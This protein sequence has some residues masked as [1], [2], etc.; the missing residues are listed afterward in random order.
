MTFRPQHMPRESTHL[1]IGT[2]YHP[3]GADNGEMSKYLIPCL[4]V[5]R[6]N[7]PYNVIMLCE[8]F[9]TLKDSR[10]RCSHNLKQ[11]VQ[12]HTQDSSTV[13]LTYTNIQDLYDSPTVQPAIGLSD[14]M[15]VI[16]RPK[17]H[18]HYSRP[19]IQRV[20]RR[21]INYN[22]KISFDNALVTTKWEGLYR[23]P[24]CQDQYEFL[25]TTMSG[26]INQFSSLQTETMLQ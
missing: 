15:V 13:D 19:T 5:V 8:I 17:L 3:P 25:E 18:P 21:A 24:T 10:L 14:H 22:S 4:D 23:L 9:N 7:H 12:T 11:I 1:T 6:R 26:L 2:V 20:Q 16:T